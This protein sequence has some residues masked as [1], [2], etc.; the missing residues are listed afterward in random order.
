[1]RNATMADAVAISEIFV[2]AFPGLLAS[3]FGTSNPERLTM[4]LA[5]TIEGG[6]LRLDTLAVVEVAGKVA[7][8]A[9][10]Q[11]GKPITSGS[12]GGYYRAL[13]PRTGS[14]QAMLCV[15]GGLSY[16]AFDARSPFYSHLLYLEAIAVREE[17]RGAGIGR[18]LL[19]EAENRA[20]DLGKTHIGLHVIRRRAR[21][22]QLYINSGYQRIRRIPAQPYTTWPS[23]WGGSRITWY[24][25]KP[26]NVGLDYTTPQK[27][28]A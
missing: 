2:E 23:R 5:A 20:A 10:F 15:L 1:M 12:M 4:I 18:L 9:I 13:R 8:A 25:E 7:G 11:D 21:A 28:E 6:F 24:M 14:M 17:L 19:S 16:T 22:R 27:P 3:C 26:V